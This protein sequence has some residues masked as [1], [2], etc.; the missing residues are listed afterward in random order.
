MHKRIKDSKYRVAS[1]LKRGKPHF[2]TDCSTQGDCC[3]LNETLYQTVSIFKRIINS[4][5]NFFD[6]DENYADLHR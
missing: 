1:L 6:Y 2:R 5:F 4:C 3:V